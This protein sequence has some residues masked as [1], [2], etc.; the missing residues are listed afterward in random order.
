MQCH[1][2]NGLAGESLCTLLHA[3][4]EVDKERALCQEITT[5]APQA[6]WAWRRLG[7]LQLNSGDAEAA[8]ASL[9]VALRGDPSHGASW[10]CLAAAYQN[11]G[12]L[13]AALKVRYRIGWKP[14]QTHCKQL[15]G[16]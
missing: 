4:D 7:F 3:A 15:E 2:L 9:Q 11:L 14:S 8:I 1:K 12:R 16:E 13:T 10:Q 5:R 6:L